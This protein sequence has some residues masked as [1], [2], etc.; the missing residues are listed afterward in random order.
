MCDRPRLLRRARAA[1]SAPR[2]GT[3]RSSP[4][5]VPGSIVR[6]ACENFVTYDAVEFFPGPYLNMIIGPNGTGK[7]TVVCAIALGL[8][9][10][11][12]VLG[13]AK[14]IASYVKLGHEQGWVEIELQG[15]PGNGNTTVRRILFRETNSS[16]WMLNGRNASAKEITEAVSPFHIEVGNLCAFLPQDRVA[17]FACMSPSRLL[18]ETQHAAGHPELSEWHASLISQGHELAKVKARVER[19][20]QEHDHLEERNLVL[21]RDVRRY[22]ER[23]ELEKRV[24]MLQARI[25][26]AQYREAKQRYDI[27]H[28]ERAEAKEAVRAAERALQPLQ[29]EREYV[30][31][32][33]QTRAAKGPK[34]R[35][36]SH[37]SPPRCGCDARDR[38]AHCTGPRTRRL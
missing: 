23:V 22:E 12:S 29:E 30:P 5:F 19:D 36:A 33:T 4:S 21:E 9:W 11:P 38:Q 25:P 24:T 17:D 27:A 6:V 8:G 1:A 20:V 26:Y 3:S 14:D 10:K 32:L 2:R 16:D 13:R 31:I 37:R 28:A 15:Y 18:Q 7:S 35:T 34:D